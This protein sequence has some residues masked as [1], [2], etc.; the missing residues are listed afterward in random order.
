MAALPDCASLSIQLNNSL[1]AGRGFGKQIEC[2]H[3]N[4]M[5]FT[6]L[7]QEE[8]ERPASLMVQRQ[9]ELKQNAHAPLLA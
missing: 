8:A 7:H 3:G 6:D 9:T 1:V 2:E 5:K 4:D